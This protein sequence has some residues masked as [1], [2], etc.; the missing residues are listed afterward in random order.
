[1]G[2]PEEMLLLMSELERLNGRIA[3][4]N[5]LSTGVE[6]VMGQIREIRNNMVPR[7]AMVNLMRRIQMLEMGY[8]DGDDEIDEDSEMEDH[9]GYT[10]A[11][12]EDSEDESNDE[13]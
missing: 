13:W 9:T 11:C 4:M 6:E 10:T 5:C 3:D 7:S 8:N 1:M 12:T 2:G